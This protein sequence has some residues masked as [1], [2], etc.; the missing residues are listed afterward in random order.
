MGSLLEHILHHFSQMRDA[1]GKWNAKTA[2]LRSDY[3]ILCDTISLL[4]HYMK[5]TNLI[6]VNSLVLLASLLKGKGINT[7]AGSFC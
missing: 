4:S 6:D 1:D 5:Q 3:S 7:N 2:A